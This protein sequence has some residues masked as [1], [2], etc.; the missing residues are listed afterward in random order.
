MIKLFSFFKGKTHLHFQSK[1]LIITIINVGIK[2]IYYICGSKKYI[3]LIKIQEIPCKI[4]VSS[5]FY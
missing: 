1:Q 5:D 2:K 4:K 3:V